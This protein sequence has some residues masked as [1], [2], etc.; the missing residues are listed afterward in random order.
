VKN[1][2]SSH[3]KG[4]PTRREPPIESPSGLGDRVRQLRKQRGLTLRKL[5]TEIGVST[6]ALCR[7]EKGETRPKKSNI[8]ALADAFRLTEPE[9]LYGTDAGAPDGLAVSAQGSLRDVIDDSKARIA[10][11]AGTTASRIKIIIEV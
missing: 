9:L 10:R 1:Y 11:A 7:W 3:F 8:Q 4:V 6:P 5:A 2:E